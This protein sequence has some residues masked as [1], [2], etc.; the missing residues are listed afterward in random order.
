MADEPSLFDMYEANAART[1]RRA[2]T[3][4]P[5]PLSLYASQGGVSWDKFLPSEERAMQSAASLQAGGDYDP[6]DVF[7]GA[8]G[9][10][11]APAQP[12]SWWP[13]LA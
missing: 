4:E 3:R 13:P 8:L 12:G 10:V 11:G 5:D 1:R 2:P 7:L 9:A 6:R